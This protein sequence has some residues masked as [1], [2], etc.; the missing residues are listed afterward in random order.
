MKRISL[1][2]LFLFALL[3]YTYGQADTVQK[4]STA[5]FKVL[6]TN[7]KNVPSK[8]DKITFANAKTGKTYSGVSGQDGRFEIYI[9]KGERLEVRFLSLGKDSVLRTIDVPNN[10]GKVTLNYTLKYEL[11]RI[12]TLDNVYFDSNKATLKPASFQTL[13]N[14]VELLNHKP[15]M[16]MEIAGHTDNVGGAEINKKL[17]QGRADAVKAYLVKKGINESR[18]Q[19]V[20]YGLTQP[21]DTNNTPEGRKN[22]RRTEAHI[23]KE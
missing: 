7:L 16:E 4:D 17:S 2:L 15:T 8:G 22:N 23:L 21:V 1:P 3:S 9:P 20:G 12:I 11:P 13:D 18:I 14:L 10:R 6:V 19:A 5:L